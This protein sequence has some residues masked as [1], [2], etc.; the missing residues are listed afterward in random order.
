[1]Q[2]NYYIENEEVKARTAAR[3]AAPYPHGPPAEPTW[4]RRRFLRALS[5]RNALFGRSICCL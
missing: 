4:F 2:S 3:G 1:M 5:G